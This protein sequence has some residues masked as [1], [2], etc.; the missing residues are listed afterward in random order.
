MISNDLKMKDINNLRTS[1][2]NTNRQQTKPI[3]S[4]RYEYT[5]IGG[6]NQ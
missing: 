6:K 1:L 3:T 5:R 4:L 2:V